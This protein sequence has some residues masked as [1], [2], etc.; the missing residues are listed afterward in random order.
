MATNL[1]LGTRR[2]IGWLALLGFVLVLCGLLDSP[3]W[4]KFVLGLMESA[5][6]SAQ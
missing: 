2:L 1:S 3:E 6:R 5:M 4:V